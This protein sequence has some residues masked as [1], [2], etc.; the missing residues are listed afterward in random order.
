MILRTRHLERKCKRDWTGNRRL[1]PMRFRGQGDLG[2]P[3]LSRTH[4]VN[5][6]VPVERESSGPGLAPRNALG[7]EMNHIINGSARF[8]VAVAARRL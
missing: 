7:E 3:A 1:W 2:F 5:A 6:G 4:V 8:D